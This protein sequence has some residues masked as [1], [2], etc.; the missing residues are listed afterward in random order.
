[1]QRTEQW[2]RLRRGKLTA[3]NMGQAVGLTPWGSPRRLAETIRA[4]REPEDADKPAKK[5]KRSIVLEHGTNN[6]PNGLLEY[7]VASGNTVEETGY[8]QHDALD[9]VGGSPDGL[10]GAD[11]LV[12]IKCPFSRR[13]YDEVPAYYYCQVNALMEITGRQ[14]CDLCCWT[15]DAV[16]IWRIKANPLAWQALLCHYTAFFA[17]VCNGRDPPDPSASLLPK[18]RV[19]IEQDATLREDFVTPHHAF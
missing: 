10:I 13:L 1:M 6:E 11:G 4:D 5:Q 18:V 12:E 3:S 7:M 17:C 8:W 19:W 9:W 14:W 15:P 16:K 2:H